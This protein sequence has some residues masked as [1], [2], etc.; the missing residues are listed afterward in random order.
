M[1][2]ATR[3]DI[4]EVIDIGKKQAT[5]LFIIAYSLLR[6]AAISATT[7]LGD[8]Q[9]LGDTFRSSGRHGLDQL[10]VVHTGD[11]SRGAEN[12]DYNLRKRR[13]RRL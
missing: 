13:F 10:S 7:Q 2:R 11:Y 12:D 5:E 8:Y 4:T 6:S 9:L 3:A 1:W